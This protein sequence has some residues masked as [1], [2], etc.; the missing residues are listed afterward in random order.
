MWDMLNNNKNAVAFL[1]FLLGQVVLALMWAA[2][3]DQKVTELVAKV[4]ILDSVGG[5]QV[6]STLA[7]ITNLERSLERVGEML[8]KLPVIDERVTVLREQVVEMNQQ[9]KAVYKLQSENSTS[10]DIDN[11]PESLKAPLQKLQKEVDEEVK[12]GK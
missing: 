3:I 11:L 7:R 10:V 6:H 8:T 5:R 4:E 2:H 12:N 1:L 9:T